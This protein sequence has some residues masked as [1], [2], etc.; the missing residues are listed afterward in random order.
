MFKKETVRILS[1]FAML[2]PAIAIVLLVSSFFIEGIGNSVF[3][4]LFTTSGS[5]LLFWGGL[6][7]FKMCSSYNLYEEE[8]KKIGIRVIMIIIASIIIIFVGLPFALFIAAAIVAGIW[9]VKKNTD[10]WNDKK[11]IEIEGGK[12]L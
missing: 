8:Y 5:A 11:D 1:I 2:L 7:A 4:L 6:L 12:N 9:S 3:G 10:E